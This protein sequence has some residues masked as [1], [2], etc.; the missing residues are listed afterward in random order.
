MHMTVRQIDNYLLPPGI[1]IFERGWLSA[2][3]IFL[4]SDDDVSLVDSGYCSHQQLTVD[5]VTN[6][7]KQYGLSSIHKLVNTHLHSDHCGGNKALSKKFDC[8]IWI[9]KA[10]AIAVQHWD[11]DLLSFR[12]LGQDCPRFTHQGLLVPG[13]EIILGRYP[14]QILAAP[15]HDNHSVMLY[16]EQH[17]I[18]ISADALWEQGFGVIF[19]ELWGEGGFEEVAKTLELIEGLS[20]GLV[21]PGHGKPF[22]DVKQ[23]L[24]IAKSRLDYLSSDADRNARHGAKVL[25]KYKL[26]EWRTRDLKE[27]CQWIASTPALDNARKQLNMVPEDFQ[28][29]LPQA[30]VKSHAAVI[31]RDQLINLD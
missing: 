13:E 20:V 29:W 16:Q 10:E 14:W 5:L 26:L 8:E 23:S 19:P 27:V 3:N 4:Y 7:L 31:E 21:I 2:N 11:E 15:G 22:T 1:D 24:Q 25:L 12:Q 28:E 30:L 17:Q 18:L 6:A 9:P